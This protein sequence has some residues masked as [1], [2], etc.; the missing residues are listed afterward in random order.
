MCAYQAECEVQRTVQ[1]RPTP[2]ITVTKSTLNI[3]SVP[4]EI[5]SVGSAAKTSTDLS[6]VIELQDRA[7]DAIRHPVFDDDIV[8]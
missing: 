7:N 3:A 4:V 8:A 2:S 5:Q 6:I 1:V